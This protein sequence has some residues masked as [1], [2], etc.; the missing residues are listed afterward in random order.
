MSAVVKF[1]LLQRYSMRTLHHLAPGPEI[2]SL[3]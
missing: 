2:G 1:F 3:G